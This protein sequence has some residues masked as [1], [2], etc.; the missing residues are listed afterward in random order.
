M[1][2]LQLPALIIG[3]QASTRW[4][5][6]QE[7]TA[8]LPRVDCLMVSPDPSIGID[9]VREIISFVNLT[10]SQGGGK[11]VIIKEAQTMTPEAQNAA[12]KTL[13]EPPANVLLI[14]TSPSAEH[15][16]PTI[17]SRCQII[18]LGLPAINLGEPDSSPEI[19][20]LK[21]ALSQGLAAC[22]SLAEKYSSSKES[23][24]KWLSLVIMIWRHY[25]LKNPASPEI[26]KL[27]SAV[28]LAERA[29]KLIEGNINTRLTLEIFLLDLLELRYN[30]SV[31]D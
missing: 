26:K 19:F 1:R 4:Q 10:A 20:E 2:L 30:E 3:S 5:K 13:E 23:C 12:L 25:F 18:N 7:L 14:L 8:D 11:A 6:A 29:R 21:E 24:L 17:V 15:L 16:L 22:L 28:R 9:Q 27:L 31:G